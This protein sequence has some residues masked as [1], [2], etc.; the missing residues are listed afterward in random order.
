[1]L[2]LQLMNVSQL[3]DTL[4]IHLLRPTRLNLIPI[5]SLIPYAILELQCTSTLYT[6]TQSYYNGF[7]NDIFRS[8]CPVLSFNF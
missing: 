5:S 8:P 6:H 3:Q 7:V 2:Y 4:I 1:M